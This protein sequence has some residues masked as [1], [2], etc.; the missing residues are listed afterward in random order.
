[1]VLRFVLDSKA[2]L[3]NH[4]AFFLVNPV[5]NF[6]TSVVCQLSANPLV[7]LRYKKAVLGMET[8]ALSFF[9]LR[10]SFSNGEKSPMNF[11][12]FQSGKADRRAQKIRRN[13]SRNARRRRK[14]EEARGP[15]Q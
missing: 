3:G 12:H 13:K 4:G 11:G 8:K 7:K 1:M 2:D 5:C 14:K 15:M 9:F 10:I 6:L